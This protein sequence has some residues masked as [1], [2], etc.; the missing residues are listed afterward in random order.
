MPES[1]VEPAVALTVDRSLWSHR[2]RW[3]TMSASPTT[4][5]GVSSLTPSMPL[6]PI[7]GRV[8]WLLVV[9]A[10]TLVGLG[11]FASLAYGTP[12]SAAAAGS[13]AQLLV[14]ALGTAWIWAALTPAVLWLIRNI[15]FDSGRRLESAGYYVASGLGFLLVS[16]VLEWLLGQVTGVTPAGQF[17]ATLLGGHL[18]TRILAFLA[19]V[20]LGWA[21]RYLALYRT[22]HLHASD[23][24]A[25]LAKTHLQVLK[26]QLQPHFLFN[27]LNAIAELVHTDPEAA[28]QMIMRL[29]RLLRLSLDHA[30]H[31]VV[32]LRQEADFLR[33]YMEIEQVRF[34]DRLQV[35]WDLASDTLD[36]AVPTLLWQPVLE[37]AIRHGV[38]P[39]AG[40]GRIVITSRRE[41]EDLVL[42]ISDNG[43]GL[44]PGGAPRQGVG[45]RNVRERVEQLYGPRARFV[46]S[47]A[48]GGGTAATL[49]LPFV[50]CEAPHTPVPL[51][52]SSLEELAR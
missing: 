46:L 42:E 13:Q 23:L 51:R 39:L 31:Q 7:D 36:A 52:G 41:S 4:G 10:W 20:T 8:G 32:P 21:A 49:R 11:Y 25:R 40:R 45:L 48:V 6:L 14:Y 16:G 19:M 50:H 33:V 30:S 1:F 29:G 22:R 2:A 47:P 18:D 34:Q 3:G 9:S 26:M 43:R 24:E 27:T 35:V 28:D 5:L 12:A 17:P 15:T 37:N 44:P 38:T